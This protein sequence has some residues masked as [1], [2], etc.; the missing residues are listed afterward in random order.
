MKMIQWIKLNTV[1]PLFIPKELLSL[2]EE[3]IGI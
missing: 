1:S 3:A 2:V